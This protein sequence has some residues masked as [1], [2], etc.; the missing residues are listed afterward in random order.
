VGKGRSKVSNPERRIS[1]KVNDKRESREKTV[2][3]ELRTFCL[4]TYEGVDECRG[5]TPSRPGEKKGLRN[6][7]KRADESNSRRGV[8]KDGEGNPNITDLIRKFGK[9]ARKTSLN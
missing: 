2:L 8:Q 6:P 5:Q 1:E 7:C 9:S 3:C 4:R